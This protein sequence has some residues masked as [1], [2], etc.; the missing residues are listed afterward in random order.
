MDDAAVVDRRQRRGDLAGD[1][2]HL[3]DTHARRSARRRVAILV[4]HALEAMP[5]RLAFEKLHDDAQ[6]ALG[7]AGVVVDFHQTGVA[8]H[9]DQPR[10]VDEALHELGLFRQ[11]RVQDLDGGALSNVVVHRL[12]DRAH[13]AFAELAQLR[14]LPIWLPTMLL[15]VVNSGSDRGDTVSLAGVL[16]RRRSPSGVLRL[17][18]IGRPLSSAATDSGVVIALCARWANQLARLPNGRPS[19]VRRPSTRD[20]THPAPPQPRTLATYEAIKRPSIIVSGLA[21]SL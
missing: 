6:R 20:T 12:E 11:V 5:Q 13:A 1:L 21:K 4:T 8:N 18:A 15:G 7:G 10:L 16:R 3:D 2:Q 9:A 17:E 19:P 14:Y